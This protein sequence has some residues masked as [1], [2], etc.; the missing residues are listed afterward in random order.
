MEHHFNVEIAKKFGVNAAIFLNNVAYWLQKN[1]ANKKHFHENRYWTYN[2]SE[3]LAI[4][5]PYWSPDQIDRL[6]KKCISLKLLLVGNFNDNTYNRTRWYSL[7]DEAL[8]MFNLAI[9][10]NRGMKAA[11]SRTPFR[12]IAE[13]IKETD[14]KPDIKTNRAKKIVDNFKKPASRSSVNLKI[15]PKDFEPDENGMKELYRVAKNVKMQTVELFDKFVSVHNKYKTKSS[16]WQQKFIGFL[17]DEKPK[18][19]YEDSTGKKRRYDNNP[20]Y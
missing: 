20:L 4:L 3:A 6:I 13:S 18:K 11:K 10:R 9:P 15:L 8:N 16:N 12:E 19:T 5:F 7:T 14:N 1:Q 2:S 17:A